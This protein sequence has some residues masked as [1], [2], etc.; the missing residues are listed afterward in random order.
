[1]AVKAKEVYNQAN[2]SNQEGAESEPSRRAIDA[3]WQPK[4]KV[5]RFAQAFIRGL[6]RHCYRRIIHPKHYI[7]SSALKT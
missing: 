6:Y 7:C 4:S 3:Q 2:Q 1:M 5:I